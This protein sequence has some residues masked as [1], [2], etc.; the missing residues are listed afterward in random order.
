MFFYDFI[1]EIV[2]IHEIKY[3]I[4]N[5]SMYGTNHDSLVGFLQSVPFINVDFGFTKSKP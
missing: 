2:N 4:S 3:K 1:V 5:H